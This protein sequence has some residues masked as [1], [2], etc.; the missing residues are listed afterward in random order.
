MRREVD[1]F[2]AGLPRTGDV[3]EL[4]ILEVGNLVPDDLCQS[5]SENSVRHDVYAPG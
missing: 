1:G 2:K 3:D 4:G 5:V